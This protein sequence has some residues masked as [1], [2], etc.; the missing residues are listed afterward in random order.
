[1][2]A[3]F[4]W[5]LGCCIVL[6]K[7][8]KSVM[9]DTQPYTLVMKEKKETTMADRATLQV[10]DAQGTPDMEL[11]LTD[12]R[13]LLRGAEVLEHE[14]EQAEETADAVAGKNLVA[15]LVKHMVHH[16]LEE[17]E[18]AVERLAA[19]VPLQEIDE[20]GLDSTGFKIRL[21]G[22]GHGIIH[23][24]RNAIEWIDACAFV[25]KVD[26]ARGHSAA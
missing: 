1:M 4:V 22:H 12:S 26:E 3:F 2:L 19:G 5:L 17:S 20:I 7:G 15:R 11:V 9:R 8:S 13:L 25:E 23:L 16:Q 21:K 18:R 24:D 14:V 6:H 10:K